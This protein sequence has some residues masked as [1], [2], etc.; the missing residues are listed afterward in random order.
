VLRC[1]LRLNLCDWELF[2]FTPKLGPVDSHSQ[3][4]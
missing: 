4:I 1:R 3:T 2:G